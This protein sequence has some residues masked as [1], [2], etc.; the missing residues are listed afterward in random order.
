MA[1][2]KAVVIGSGEQAAGWAARFALAGWPVVA[3]GQDS[4]LLEKVMTR[5]RRS[6]PGL[7]D[8][9]LPEEGAVTCQGACEG[10][11]LV[12]LCAPLCAAVPPVWVPPTAMRIVALP[13]GAALSCAEAKALEERINEG[14]LALALPDGP[15][16]LLPEAHLYGTSANHANACAILRDVGMAV[17]N[18]HAFGVPI[19]PSA[20][21]HPLG[22]A[23]RPGSDQDRA[24]VGV[25][26]A[27]KAAGVGAG[28]ALVAR[29]EALAQ[30]AGMARSLADLPNPAQPVK[31]L[32]RAVPLDW[33]DYNGHMTE[34]RYL[35]VFGWSTDRV[36]EIIGCDSAYI[37]AGNSFFTVETHLRHIEEC[38]A[39]ELIEVE[40]RVLGAVGKKMHL[41]HEMR[42][43]N[44]A[45]KATGEHLL[46][47][48]NLTQR[49]STPPLGQVDQCL[50]ALA[51]AQS[52]LQW[53]QNAGRAIAP[54][55]RQSLSSHANTP[56]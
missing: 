6:A 41:W 32:A 15:P 40:S 47:H 53:P 28:R 34:A 43:S 18:P 22:L 3:L 10:A 11:R 44:G 33:L 52:A 20:P 17:M 14:W 8:A 37:A 46:L 51:Q 42:G 24:L 21:P 12:L 48:V 55:T 56:R 23:H 5:A 2:N 13:A 54:A 16:F 19:Q 38:H 30:N 9:P 49:R 29:D 45:L 27:L 25:L 36:M 7:A 31:T 26:R 35:D 39:G 50:K 4:L 1:G